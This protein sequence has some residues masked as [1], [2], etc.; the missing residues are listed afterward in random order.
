MLTITLQNPRI[1]FNMRRSFLI[2]ISVFFFIKNSSIGQ[3]ILTPV[4]SQVYVKKKWIRVDTTNTLN[5]EAL[6]D[7]FRFRLENTKQYDSIVYQLDGLDKEPIATCDPIIRYTNLKGGNYTFMTWNKKDSTLSHPTHL[8]I[9]IDS[10]LMETW[11]FGPSIAFY[12]LL[13]AS[14]IIY[15]WLLYNFRQKMRVQ[16]I[17]NQIAGDLH[18]EV[19]STLSSI[20]IFTKALRR[21]FAEKEP[22]ALPILDKILASS[23]ETITNLRDTVWAIHPDNDDM[24][25]LLEKMRAFAY[26]VLTAQDIMVEY[27]SNYNPKKPLRISMEQRRNVYLMFK[28]AVN[29][30][31]KHSDASKT[32]IDIKQEKNGIRLTIKDN[33]KGFDQLRGGNDGNG[34]KNFNKRAKESFIEFNLKTKVSEGTEIE[35]FVPEI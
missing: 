32:F 16:N 24:D 9:N 5:L 31:L 7:D 26:Q 17:R 35:M 2:I 20:A 13:M 18:D 27:T 14:A 19:G 11:W 21:D 25:K 28:E 29:N 33:G 8:N 34:L 30:I 1:I 10:A 22:D 4:I 3:S 12:L 15:F 6:D 23:Q